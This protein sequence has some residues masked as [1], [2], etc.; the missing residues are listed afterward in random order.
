LMVDI[1][2]PVAGLTSYVF[3]LVMTGTTMS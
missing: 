2:T 1:P 3:P